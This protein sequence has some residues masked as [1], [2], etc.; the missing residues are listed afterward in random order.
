MAA[1]R[2]VPGKEGKQFGVPLEAGAFVAHVSALLDD[3]QASLLRQAQEFRDA[4]IV[5]VASYEELQAA[6]AEGGCRAGL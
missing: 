5:E 6:V 3:I 4:N 1:R 2:D